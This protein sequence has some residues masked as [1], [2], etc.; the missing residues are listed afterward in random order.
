M[1]PFL[2]CSEVRDGARCWRI[3]FPDGQGGET[4][5]AS[6]QE[7]FEALCSIAGPCFD[8]EVIP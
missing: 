6:A 7:A 8:L 2:I 1:R 5:W 4:L 3:Y